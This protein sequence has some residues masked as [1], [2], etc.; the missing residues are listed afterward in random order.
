MTKV[1]TRE[2]HEY[3]A[4]LNKALKIRASIERASALRTDDYGP[5]RMLAAAREWGEPQWA[6]VCHWS[7]VPA[8]SAATRELVISLLRERVKIARAS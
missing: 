6:I 3:I 7:G 1:D 2:K 4:R 5:D 8:A